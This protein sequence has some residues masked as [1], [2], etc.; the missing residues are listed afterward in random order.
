MKDFQ[1]QQKFFE[2]TSQTDYLSSAFDQDDDIN[3]S[4]ERFLKRLNTIIY[5]SFRKVRITE[6]RDFTVEK[7]IEERKNLRN[8]NDEQSKSKLDEV[9]AELAKLCADANKKKIEEELNGFKCNEGGVNPGKL[10]KLRRKLFPN[11]RDPPTAMYDEDDNLVTSKT[12]IEKLA[13][14]T[15]KH[16]LEIF[17]F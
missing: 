4:T 5:K 10:W 13:V 12:V 2:L 14:Q 11:S 7:L 1:C 3:K 15:Y 16:C 17:K 8:K 6:K 9:E